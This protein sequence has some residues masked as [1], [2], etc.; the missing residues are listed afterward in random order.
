[1]EEVRTIA[2]EDMRRVIRLDRLS[3]SLNGERPLHGI[4]SVRVGVTSLSI[5][6]ALM[7]S[8]FER[9]HPHDSDSDSDSDEQDGYS[10][11]IL[12]PGHN[13]PLTDIPSLRNDVFD[14]VFRSRY[15][16]LNDLDFS[17]VLVAGG[18]VCNAIIGRPPYGDIDMFIYG[19]SE[20]EANN[21]V[22]YMVNT[23]R[24]GILNRK[25]GTSVSDHNRR[26]KHKHCYF[27]RRN[28]YF[29][30][31]G[32]FQ[33]IFRLYKDIAEIL[34]G[35]DF[36]ACSV[37]YDGN[38]V[39]L[40]ESA[41]FAYETGYNVLD[42]TRRSTTYEK[43]LLKYHKRGFGLILPGYPT[44]I[45]IEDM[46]H[47]LIDYFNTY[48]G[49]F[50]D[51]DY[52][53]DNHANTKN[54]RRC[55]SSMWGPKTSEL[56]AASILRTPIEYIDRVVIHTHGV[57]TDRDMKTHGQGVINAMLAEENLLYPNVKIPKDIT[58]TGAFSYPISLE[59]VINSLSKENTD[60]MVEII[61]R[62]GDWLE[63][64][65]RHLVQD[66]RNKVTIVKENMKRVDWIKDNPG[67]QLTSSINPI[68]ED[69]RDWYG[70]SY[71]P[72]RLGL[73]PC[74]VSLI[75]FGTED[76][77]ST[78]HALCGYSGLLNII[79]FHLFTSDSS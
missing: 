78:L 42:T 8:A 9:Y 71:T 53:A 19:L 35:F 60:K 45:S 72:Y 40:S 18:A 2:D 30:Q 46:D 3:R 17:N 39:Y 79:F 14:M 47:R 67:T 52:F 57:V 48:R 41:K 22:K 23:I 65:N 25:D 63:F 20:E 77:S 26:Y 32:K 74:I 34:Y 44:D 50:S 29:I 13:P 11:P 68:V 59:R 56:N 28:K 61:R 66:Y 4:E 49:S 33:I 15:P 62:G 51:S 5:S 31:I 27:S 10:K 76:N 12:V 64:F 55:Y 7:E 1:M 37:G 73:K 69:P 70:K 36:G 16:E 54:T 24:R 38:N 43:R 6:C 58:M 21:K 75:L